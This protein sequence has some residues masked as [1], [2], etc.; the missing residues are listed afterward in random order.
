MRSVAESQTSVR[1]DSPRSHSRPPWPPTT[2]F[3]SAYVYASPSSFSPADPIS[4]C[5]GSQYTGL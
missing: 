5:R 3:A 2:V 1:L 4:R